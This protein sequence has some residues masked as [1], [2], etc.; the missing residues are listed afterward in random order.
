MRGDLRVRGED[1]EGGSN[2]PVDLAPRGTTGRDE[3][4]LALQALRPESRALCFLQ[5]LKNWHDEHD[6]KRPPLTHHRCLRHPGLGEQSVLCPSRRYAP[7]ACQHPCVARPPLQ[8]Y[9]SRVGKRR[10]VTRDQRVLEE[11]C[12]HRERPVSCSSG[13][14]QWLH[15][16]SCANHRMNASPPTP[17]SPST[18]HAQHTLCYTVQLFDALKATEARL[19][20]EPRFTNLGR[21]QAP[22][23]SRSNYNFQSP[24]QQPVHIDISIER[25]GGCGRHAHASV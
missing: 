14:R 17:S 19:P 6:R 12:T 24:P 5:L 25:F 8:L 7:T 2:L 21:V 20:E 16:Q 15:L 23:T 13:G 9:H 3:L 22:G 18:A 4:G 10:Q 11:W 1:G